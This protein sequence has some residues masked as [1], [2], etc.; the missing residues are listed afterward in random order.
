MYG[1]VESLNL[2]SKFVFLQS[3][4]VSSDISIWQFLGPLLVGG[5]SIILDDTTNMSDYFTLIREFEINLIEVVPSVLKMLLY[6]VEHCEQKMK[7]LAGLQYLMVT[8]ETV[9]KDLINRWLL[10]YPNIP[11]VN[12]YG[13][14]E[15]ADDVCQEIIYSVPL[16][17]KF[18][19]PIGS[20]LPNIQLFVMDSEFT[21]VAAYVHGEIFVGGICVGN[22]Y[23]RNSELTREKFIIHPNF[24]RLYKTGD[25]GYWDHNGKL[26]FVGRLDRQLKIKGRRI[27]PSEIEFIMESFP[28]VDVAIVKPYGPA[29]HWSGLWGFVERSDSVSEDDLKKF[30]AKHLPQYMIPDHFDIRLSLPKVPNGKVDVNGLEVIVAPVSAVNGMQSNAALHFIVHLYTDIFE[31][32]KVNENSDFLGLGGNSIMV[33]T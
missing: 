13:P 20:P 5:S 19:V 21:P 23:V 16:D 22:G 11:V 24:G 8:G 18:K 3:A 1:Q 15:T 14:S 4:P 29:G 6:E 12:A 33:T 25:L 9:P 31:N 26:Q 2:N 10:N 27:E 28:G 30:L 32:K 17:P 7:T